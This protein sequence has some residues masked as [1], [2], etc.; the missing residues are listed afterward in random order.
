MHKK[1]SSYQDIYQMAKSIDFIPSNKHDKSCH[2]LGL[3][4]SDDMYGTHTRCHI[5]NKPL[6]QITKTCEPKE[7]IIRRFTLPE[8]RYI[9]KCNGGT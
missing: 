7:I 8:Y 3:A 2:P 4:N 5:C 6:Y 9:W 1:T